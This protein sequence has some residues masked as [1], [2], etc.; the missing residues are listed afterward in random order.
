HGAHPAHRDTAHGDVLAGQQAAGLG[1]MHAHPPGR[2]GGVQA[3][4]AEHDVD[5]AEHEG[6]DPRG[7]RQPAL[8]PRP[9]ARDPHQR[10]RRRLQNSLDDHRA[11]PPNRSCNRSSR[12]SRLPIMAAQSLRSGTRRPGSAACPGS[13]TGPTATPSMLMSACAEVELVALINGSSM[14]FTRFRSAC[15][16]SAAW[17]NTSESRFISAI[18]ERVSVPCTDGNRASWVVIRSISVTSR[19]SCAVSA[20]TTSSRSEEHTSELQSRENLVC[21]LL[22]EKKNR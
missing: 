10:L 20:E 5:A 9:G 7:R 11:P 17:L 1:Q 22:L 15:G 21:R 12:N 8:L 4:G 13:S 18:T 16:L 3:P 14:L 6:G 2:G 19:S